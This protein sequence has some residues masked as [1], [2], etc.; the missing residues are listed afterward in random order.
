MPAL[1]FPRKLYREKLDKQ[2]ERFLDMLRQVNVSLPVTEVLLQIPAY[3]K[4]LKEILTKKRKIEETKV[5]KLIE[6]C[7]AILQNKIPQEYGDPESSTIPCS[8]G[9]L[10]FDKSLCDSGASINLMPLS[11][12]RKLEKEVGEIRSVPISLQLAN[13]MTITPEGVVKDVLVRVDKFV[14]PV[15]FIVVNIEENKEVPFVLGGL[16]LATGRAILD[17]HDRKLMLLRPKIQ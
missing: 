5:V 10:N 1:P 16:F 14:F 6:H 13:Q 17:I 8:L 12:H 11:I 9:T 7:R 2:F 15:D 3:A 4:F